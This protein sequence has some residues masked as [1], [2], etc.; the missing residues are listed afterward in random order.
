SSSAAVL[1]A[2]RSFVLPRLT[3]SSMAALALGSVAFA[4]L[5]LAARSAMRQIRARRH[6]FAGMRIVGE[7][8]AGDAL[9]FA[10]VRPQAF[11]AGLLRPRIYV[12]TGAVERL[13]DAELEA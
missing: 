6:F 7:A 4:V 9:L 2:C 5:A 10:D 8:P 12:S 1:A 3:L 11:C 13:G